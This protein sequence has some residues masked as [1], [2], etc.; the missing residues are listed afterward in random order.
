MHSR[1]PQGKVKRGRFSG[2]FSCQQ[3][4]HKDIH[5][6]TK[7]PEIT[8]GTIHPH[9][10]FNFDLQFNI[11]HPRPVTGRNL[12]INRLMLPGRDTH[13]LYFPRRLD[14]SDMPYQGRSVTRYLRPEY[15]LQT[16]IF[17]IRKF[18]RLKKQLP[19]HCQPQVLKKVRH[20]FRFPDS[21]YPISFG[22][23]Q[24]FDKPIRPSLRRKIKIT[25]KHLP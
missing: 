19:G 16:D 15:V 21:M 17:V 8:Q 4:S 6:R 13:L 12:T 7:G 1:S 9:P 5:I 25:V 11:R 3:T 2:I 14:H 22:Y 24:P 20:L 23:S 10:L 18:V